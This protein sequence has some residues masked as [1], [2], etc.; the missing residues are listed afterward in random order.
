MHLLNRSMKLAKRDIKCAIV[1]AAGRCAC[2]SR[3]ARTHCPWPRRLDGPAAPHARLKPARDLPHS[4]AL[5]RC[6]PPSDACGGGLRRCTARAANG[7][8]SRGC[9]SPALLQAAL[10]LKA[11]LEYLRDN[12]RKVGALRG[13]YG[14]DL[15]EC[16]GAWGAFDVPGCFALTNSSAAARQATKLLTTSQKSGASDPYFNVLYFNNLACIHFRYP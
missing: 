9:G 1:A 13:C 4:K 12:R 15:C 14:R 6:N 7:R 5:R 8:C 11:Q 2:L 16:G 3:P 10:M